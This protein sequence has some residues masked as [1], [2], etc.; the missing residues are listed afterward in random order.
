[1]IKAVI[2]DMDGLLID[3]EPFWQKAEIKIFKTVGIN[4]TKE[5]CL[6][7]VGLK[8]NEVVLHWYNIQKWENKSLKKVELEI[9]KEVKQLI[10]NQGKAMKGV[11]ECLEYFKNKNLKIGLASSSYFELIE[12]T[13]QKL[14]IK[15]YFEVIHSAEAEKFG[16]PAPDV[17]LTAA[18]KLKVEPKKCLVLE[19][20]YNGILSGKNAGMKVVAV[21]EAEN[22]D[23]EKFDLADLKIKS[24]LEFDEE[25]FNI[26]NQK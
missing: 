1:M 26:I 22:Y 24:L 21:P 10:L 12:A 17:Y 14:Q 23:L 25:K 7:T 3:S 6:Q 18:K 4:L 19:D 16:K 5:M 9:I 20:S 11:S 8:I 15:K 13:L 2:F